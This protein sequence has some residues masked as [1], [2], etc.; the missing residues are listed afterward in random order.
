M[1]AFNKFQIFVQNVTRGVHNLNADAFLLLLTD[2]APNA[3]DTVVDTTTTPCTIKATSNAL[4]IAAGNGYVKGGTAIASIA[5]SQTAGTDNMTGA[6]VVFT[7]SVG[8]I[9]QFRYVVL[10]DNTAGTTATRPVI[11]WWDNGSEVNLAAGN[12]FTVDISGGILSL[13]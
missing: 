10:Y 12:S 8:A 2:T 13:T 9:A 6:N 1:A 4:E 7:A 3:A 11:G 5:D